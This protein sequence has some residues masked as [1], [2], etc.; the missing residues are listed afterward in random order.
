MIS[1][2]A[3]KL[4]LYIVLSGAVLIT[5]IPCAGNRFVDWDDM[6]FVVKNYHISTL[7]LDSLYWMLT[8][9]YQG[10]WHPL[11]WFSHA[12]DRALWG[13]RPSHHH[14]V[15]VLIHTLNVVVF[16]FLVV[17][18][19]EVRNATEVERAA[20]SR[21][22]IY[23][24]AFS[25][26]LLFGVHPLRVESVA[27]LSERKDVLCAFFFLSGLVAYL[28][29]A[30][31][32]TRAARVRNYLFCVALHLLALL[33]KPTA[34]TFPFVL[35]LLDYYPL[36]RLGSTSVKAGLVEK[37]PFLV[38][39][40]VDVVINMWAKG[41]GAVPFSYVPLY[42]R[43]MNAFYAMVF[44]IRETIF[45]THLIPL[46]QLDRGLNYFAPVFLASMILVLTVT[47]W[48]LRRAYRNDR[49]W[50]AVWFYYMITLAPMLGFYMVF[51]HAMADRYTYL[52]TL[53]FWILFGLGAARLWDGAEKL[54][55]P[56]AVK[57]FVVAC[58]VILACCYGL[59]TQSQIAVWKNTET[60][61][62]YV[63]DRA[64]YVPALAYF[65]RGKAYEDKGQIQ[66]AL[67]HYHT[68]YSLNP[69]NNKYLS[70]IAGIHVKQKDYDTSM[71]I[72]QKILKQVPENSRAHIH[73]GR[74]FALQRRLDQAQKHFE[75]ALKLDP[76]LPAAYLM[77]MLL[78]IEKNEK[79]KALEY[80][81]K[82]TDKGLEVKPSIASRLGI[83]SLVLKGTK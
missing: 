39:T 50:A 68:A 9:N 67:A 37:I 38:L 14:F 54:K 59:R 27:W 72:Y 66:K 33:S 70:R 5:F 36:R 12:V 64:R 58:V 78:H 56:I 2:R 19:Q 61:W 63:I 45:P 80:Y 6:A 49:L 13:L 31:A 24:A 10:V 47:A 83:S 40:T 55:R 25:A 81:R 32:S 71:A 62:T 82:Y 17:R 48:C 79:D 77:M 65:A 74:V 73:V 21:V 15:N 22:G 69:K 75:K 43:I 28:G 52:T 30:S 35:L 76:E 11:T 29:Y 51:R 23:V 46:Y 3:V 8:T 18:L 4:Y 20:L 7:S 57:L 60:L 53:G 16:C 34:V 41:G 42:M 26:A 1:F 44:Y